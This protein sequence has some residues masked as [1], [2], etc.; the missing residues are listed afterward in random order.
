MTFEAYE[1]ADGRPI[2]FLTFRNGNNEYRYTNANVAVFNGAFEHE[3][4]AYT[5]TAPSQSKDSDDSQLRVTLS[6]QNPIPLLY[7]EILQSN[8]TTLTIERFHF[9]DPDND[10][11]V[12]WKG[13]L[14]SVTVTDGTATLLCIPF[15]QGRDEIPRYTYQG[16]CNYYLFENATCRVLKDNF[17]FVSTIT[18]FLTP[19]LVQVAGLRVRAG[20]ID[21]LVSGALSSEELDQYWLN[22]YCMVQSG[23]FRRI[24]DNPAG[25]G[26]PL[27]PDV[28]RIPFPFVQ[29]SVGDD[30]E[31]YAG[32]NRSTDICKRKF[33]NLENY[34][35]WPT[36]PVVNPF[37]TELPPG[38]SNPD[39]GPKG[40][41]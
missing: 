6:G 36:V 21:A 13:E 1:T 26:S 3:P 23:E 7:R 16:L 37:T 33:A 29:A 9:N 18:G 22:G 32:C 17:R 8:I 19:T 27:D 12:F 14:G 40:F 15:T 35:G 25:T 5:R 20:E 2:E 39:D 4:L 10:I 34:G 41:W 28:I 11:Q 24:T 31:V 30:I 38:T